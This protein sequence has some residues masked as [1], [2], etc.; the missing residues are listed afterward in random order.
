M[1]IAVNIDKCAYVH[2]THIGLGKVLLLE[3]NLC[4]GDI[5]ID[6]RYIC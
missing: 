3:G 4:S 6:S 2:N 5:N 1:N